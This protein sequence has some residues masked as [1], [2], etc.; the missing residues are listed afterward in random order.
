MKKLLKSVAAVSMAAIV[1]LGANISNVYAVSEGNTK[2]TVIST[3]FEGTDD[4]VTKERT[5]NNATPVYVKNTKSTMAIRVGTT[6]TNT[7]MESKMFQC[8]VGQEIF[9]KSF[10]AQGS[11]VFL[12]LNMDKPGDIKGLWSPDSVGYHDILK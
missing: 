7:K 8:K 1:T 9:I 12:R 6:I 2:D 4:F 11:N 5:K 10:G 3:R